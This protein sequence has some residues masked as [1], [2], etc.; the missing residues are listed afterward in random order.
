MVLMGHLAL[1]LYCFVTHYGT[2][3]QWMP[4]NFRLSMCTH[5]QDCQ[6]SGCLG[7]LVRPSLPRPYASR[8][9]H[10]PHARNISYL[11]RPS[12]SRHLKMTEQILTSGT[13]P[14]LR[15]AATQDVPRPESKSSAKLRNSPGGRKRKMSSLAKA[16]VCR[17]SWFPPNLSNCLDIMIRT[18]S[19]KTISDY[20]KMM[21]NS[22]QAWQVFDNMQVELKFFFIC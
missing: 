18:M 11:Q 10:N 20:K 21:Q 5:R 15:P 2:V 4:L 19:E 8:L 22:V 1:I 14:W 12:G 16:L 3:L 17:K 9:L 13:S 7:R 6:T